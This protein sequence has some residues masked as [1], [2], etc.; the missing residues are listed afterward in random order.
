MEHE[1][2]EQL[3]Y[4]GV[5]LS[6]LFTILVVKRP[7][8]T[9]TPQLQTVGGG[10]RNFIRGVGIV[11][12]TITLRFITKTTSRDE[13]TEEYHH[14]ASVL[15]V[16]RPVKMVLSSERGRYCM[17]VPT[18]QIEPRDYIS[19]GSVDVQFAMEES[20]MY[21]D[22]KQVSSSGGI[23]DIVVGGN[24]ETSLTIVSTNAVRPSSSNKKFGYTT[25]NAIVSYV[26][27][28]V[29]TQSSVRIDGGE[30][31]VRVNNAAA[32]LIL[33]SDWP[34]VKPGKHR[35]ART[36]GSGEFTVSWTERW[37]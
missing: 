18:G 32:Q 36:S 8:P 10:A 7:F 30:R 6:A 4:D 37:L 26:E 13:R 12:P 3:V 16:E 15:L 20:A 24:A 25:D 33:T 1:Y 29:S 22:L 14:L 34:D 21:G 23:A 17:V 27:I 28:P 11:P 35:V 2:V 9:P 31:V 19:S 5:D